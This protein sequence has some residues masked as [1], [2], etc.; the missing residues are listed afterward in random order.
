MLHPTKP[1]PAAHATPP[2][3]TVVAAL[4]ARLRHHGA[5]DVLR[6][7]FEAVP[8]IA[9]VSSFGA[10]SVVLLHL[11]SMVKRDVPVLFIDTEMLFPETLIYQQDVAERLRLKNLKIIRAGNLQT[12]D[13]DN[14]CLLYT[15]PSPRD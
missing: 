1:L 7:A 15:S 8:D 14:T 2:A 3:E 5:T 12:H 4:N 9:M 13:P 6:A 11:T 10:E